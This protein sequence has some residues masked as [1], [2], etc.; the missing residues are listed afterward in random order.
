MPR[1]DRLS[2]FWPQM[3]LGFQASHLKSSCLAQRLFN[4]SLRLGSVVVHLL[5][6]SSQM[7]I[8]LRCVRTNKGS[9]SE[10]PKAVSTQLELA[11]Q[12]WFCSASRHRFTVLFQDHLLPSLSRWLGATLFSSEPPTNDAKLVISTSHSLLEKSPPYHRFSSSVHI[13]AAEPLSRY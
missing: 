2:G 11:H 4:A 6:N 8:D 3:S 1:G 10:D 5:E 9:K 7:S 13:K 12:V